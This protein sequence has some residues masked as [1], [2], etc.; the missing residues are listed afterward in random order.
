MSGEIFVSEPVEQV[1]RLY[2]GLVDGRAWDWTAREQ[3]EALAERLFEGHGA[4]HPGAAVEL[5]NWFPAAGDRS[6][7]G[8]FDL[9]LS[10][11]NA[12]DTVS[13]AHGFSAWSTAASGELG[14]GD[15]VFERAV[16]ALLRGD[17]SGLTTMLASA[18]DLVA[19][20]SHYGHGATLLHYLAA[21]GVE[22]YRQRVP[23][24]A[25]TLALLLIRRGA[26]PL[27]T[28]K[29]YGADQTTR[30]LLIS[31]SHPSEAGVTDEVLAVL[32]G[33]SGAA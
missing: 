12:L 29:M 8:L 26:N 9:P 32:D 16:E 4:R 24:N 22:T 27:A 13:R 11:D 18:P 23:R 2:H 30:G 1:L 3:I 31:S 17:L 7:Q 14:R 5:R 33:A 25:S 28:A 6:P 20:R 19:R 21:N 15:A 10:M